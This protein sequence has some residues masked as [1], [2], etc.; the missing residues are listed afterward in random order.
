M[1]FVSSSSS[2][3]SRIM[4]R[5]LLIMEST[6]DF[7]KISRE[8]LSGRSSESTTPRTNFSHLGINSSNLSLMKTR[9]T[10]NLMLFAFSSNMSLESSNGSMPGM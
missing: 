9:L 10:Y 7:C 6:F 1:Y 5:G 8:T 4:S 3:M 2:A